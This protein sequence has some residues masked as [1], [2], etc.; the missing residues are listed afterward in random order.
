MG[1]ERYLKVWG[2]LGSMV[3]LY[4]EIPLI[5]AVFCCDCDGAN[6]GIQVSISILVL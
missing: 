6:S 1:K 4:R 3:T 5:S 2:I